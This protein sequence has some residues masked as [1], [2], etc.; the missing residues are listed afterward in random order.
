MESMST[1][2]GFSINVGFLMGTLVFGVGSTFWGTG[3][4]SVFDDALLDCFTVDTFDLTVFSDC[5][6][7]STD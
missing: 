5:T 1:S 4:I 3:A 7:L 2:F 6:S